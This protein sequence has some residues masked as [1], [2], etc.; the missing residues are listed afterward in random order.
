MWPNEQ[1]SSRTKSLEHELALQH[2]IQSEQKKHFRDLEQQRLLDGARIA[3]L[4]K[5]VEKVEK[6]GARRVSSLECY[7]YHFHGMAIR[8]TRR[9]QES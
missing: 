7:G 9:V 5:K 2:Q 6:S 1:L 3:S 8:K 4:Q